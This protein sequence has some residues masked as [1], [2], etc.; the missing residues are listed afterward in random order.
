MGWLKNFDCLPS[1]YTDFFSLG[2]WSIFEG[3]R[4]LFIIYHLRRPP[5]CGRPCHRQ[6]CHSLRFCAGVIIFL[7]FSN[8]VDINITS[9]VKVVINYR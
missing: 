4:L 3:T 7:I 9:V 6:T 8:T 1:F 2:S 5:S